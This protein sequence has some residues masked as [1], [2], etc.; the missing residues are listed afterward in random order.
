[1]KLLFSILAG[2]ALTLAIQYNEPFMYGIALSW[3]IG[4]IG[5]PFKD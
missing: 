5:L 3:T 4:A 2:G 1:M